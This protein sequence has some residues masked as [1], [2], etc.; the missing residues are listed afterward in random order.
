[1]HQHLQKHHET[2]MCLYH[3]TAFAWVFQSID[4]RRH[5]F[6]M[7]FQSLIDFRVFFECRSIFLRSHKFTTIHSRICHRSPSRAFHRYCTKCSTSTRIKQQY[8]SRFIEVWSDKDRNKQARTRTWTKS[9]TKTKIRTRTRS[10]WMKFS[11]R[12]KWRE[13]SWKSDFCH[14]TNDKFDWY[15]RDEAV[16][17]LLNVE[18]WAFWKWV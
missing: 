9:F 18:N 16:W 14:W 4:T 8:S 5:S 2:V 10:K 3:A 15:F 6:Q 17:N 7:T 11:R 1:M 12:N 13:K